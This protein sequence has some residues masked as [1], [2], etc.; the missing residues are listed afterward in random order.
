MTER[1]FG[2][3]VVE[4][5]RRVAVGYRARLSECEVD[6]ATPAREDRNG[7]QQQYSVNRMIDV[8]PVSIQL[9]P[10]H[11]GNQETH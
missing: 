7:N 6:F 2:T 9:K 8:E 10:P 11:L 5:K 4:R 3:F 1:R